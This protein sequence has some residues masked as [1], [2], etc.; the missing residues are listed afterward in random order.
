MTPE[1]KAKGLI[2]K[3]MDHCDETNAFESY[4]HRTAIENA[5]SCATICCD[6]IIDTYLSGFGPGRKY[7]EDVKTHIQK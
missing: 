3:F 4:E 7:W 1:D 5:K 2:E 6:E